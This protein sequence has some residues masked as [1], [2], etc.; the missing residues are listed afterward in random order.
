MVKNKLDY[1]IIKSINLELKLMNINCQLNS[2]AKNLN[3]Q[4]QPRL[5]NMK[6]K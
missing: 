3:K 4:A 6:L 5:L 1:Q 2:Y